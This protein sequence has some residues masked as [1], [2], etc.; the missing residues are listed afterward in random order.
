MQPGE[1]PS[2]LCGMLRLPL[3]LFRRLLAA[4]ELE[5]QYS[6]RACCRQLR[7]QLDAHISTFPVHCPVHRAQLLNLRLQH[8]R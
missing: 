4:C 5:D 6:L 1:E 7:R 3:H 2:R 8:I